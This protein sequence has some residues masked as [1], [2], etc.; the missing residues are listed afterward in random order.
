M[1]A[2]FNQKFHLKSTHFLRFSIFSPLTLSWR[3]PMS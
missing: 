3:E 2:M 1:L